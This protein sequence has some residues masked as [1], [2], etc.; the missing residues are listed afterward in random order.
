LGPEETYEP[1]NDDSGEFHPEPG[2][3]YIQTVIGCIDP[4]EAGLA[5]VAEHLHSDPIEATSDDDRLID[6]YAAMGDLES[7]FSVGGLT[8]VDTTLSGRGRDAGT[9]RWL[10]QRAP[11]NIV[12]TTGLMPRSAWENLSAEDARSEM[13]QT[14]ERDV[15]DGLDGTSSK[16]GL[17]TIELDQAALMPTDLVAL[18]VIANAAQSTG[19][20]LRLTAST[21]GT[22][23]EALAKLITNGV[24]PSRIIVGR[25][26]EDVDEHRIDELTQLGVF[27]AFDRI[28]WNEHAADRRLAQR[29]ARLSEDGFG[30]RI[31]LS[32]GFQR[33]SQLNGYNG[34]PGLGYIV[35]QF[36][37]ML[38]EAGLDASDVR[39]VLV[40]N[41]ARA[42]SIEQS[43]RQNLR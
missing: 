2:E 23:L 18:G 22:A 24:E 39:M 17:L 20:P 25:L 41:A 43:T 14:L 27:L 13:H 37:L 7:L 38:L 4:S 30:G 6:R 33:R 12:A 32:H 1:S 34:S 36:A 19:L 8:I 28:G 15:N 35:E 31:L 29:I 3:R 16:P 42:L 9:L 5:L 40:D 26:N 11:L 21:A 10:A